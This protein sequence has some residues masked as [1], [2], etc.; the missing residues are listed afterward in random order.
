M[1]QKKIFIIQRILP[2]YRIGF[3]RNLKKLYPSLKVF[4]GNTYNGEVLKNTDNPDKETFIERKNRYFHKEGKIFFTGLYGDVIREKPDIIV[5]VFNVGNLNIYLLFILRY[6]LKFKLI[7]WSLGYDHL[8][9]FS[10]DKIFTHKVRLFLSQKA[11]AV[12]FYWD[13][14][15][16]V[17]EKYS[18][19]NSHYF[20]ARN[21]IDTNRHIALKELFDKKGKDS[22]KNY[23]DVKQKFHFIYVGRLIPDKEVDILLKAYS[24]VEKSVSDCRLTIIGDGPERIKLESLASELRIKNSVFLGEILDDEITGRWL[25]VSDAFIMPGRLGNSVVHSFCYGTPVI[26]TDKGDYFHCEGISYIKEGVN[27]YLAKDGSI[28]SLTEEMIKIISDRAL[29]DKMRINSFKTAKEDCSIEKMVDGFSE[30][31]ENV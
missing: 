10:P 3:F 8:T 27:G 11:D 31:L 18:K 14:G 13:Y 4:Y 7:L 2:H 29:I 1:M 22:I 20:V 25:Y 30:A 21:T 15:K 9:G 17:V 12:I 6:F 26:S 23:L 19:K 28:E 5:S 16:K 24:E